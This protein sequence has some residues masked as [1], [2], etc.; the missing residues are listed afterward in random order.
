MGGRNKSGPPAAFALG[1]KMESQTGQMEDLRVLMDTNVVLAIE[2]DEGA[3]HAN[4]KSASTVY[5]LVLDS[6]GQVSIV[7]NQFDDISRIKDRP[8][9]DRRRRQLEKYPRLGRVELTTRFLNEARYARDLRAQSNDGVDA[10]LLLA[11]QRN[12][13]TWLI[14]EDRKLHSHARHA[15]LQER[16][17]ILDD[18]LGVLTALSGQ[19]PVHYSVDDVQPHTIDPVQPFFDSL[20]SDYGDFSKW[21]DKVVA[22]RRI[23]MLMGA[24]SDIRGLAVLDRQ[25]PEVPGLSGNSVK[26]CTFKIAE[27]SQGRKLG[28]ALLEAVIA[29][30]RLMRGDTCF[31]EASLD[32]ESLLAML[33]EFGFFDLGPKPGAPGQI[34]LGKILEPRVDQ[35]P[36]EHPL[37]YNRRYGPGKRR[38]NRAFLVPIIPAFHSMLFPASEPQQSLFDSTYGNAIRKVYICH[39][40]IKALEPGDTLFF[41]RTHERRAVHAVGVVEETRRT[42]V[43]AEVLSFAGARTVY[44]YEELQRMCAKQVLAVKF[45]LDQV[46]ETPVSRENLKMLGVME[47]SPQSISQIRTE[48]GLQ[49]ARTL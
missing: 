6:G 24:G 38:V 25:E 15:G 36:P 37:E 31:I 45:R 7:E 18:A 20:R 23:T 48:E 4:H 39:S 43:L 33:R 14:T 3:D 1:E 29:R 27:A 22:E 13:A 40:G 9:R 12:A 26:I 41:L 19:L 17:M 8:L 16:V 35:K 47:E 46:L 49:W 2:G 32:K 28:E 34:V 21:W 10:A 44:R 30:I 11:L 5:R 42:S